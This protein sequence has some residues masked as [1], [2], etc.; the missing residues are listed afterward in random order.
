MTHVVS[1]RCIDCRYTDCCEVCPVACFYEIDDPKM[2]VIDPDTCIDCKLCVPQCPVNAI[3]G[4]DEL[5]AHYAEMLG[6]NRELVA[7]G[8]NIVDKK[9]AVA[10]ALDLA[11]VQARERAAGFEPK[12]PSEAVGG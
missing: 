4:D 11:G 3:Y 12:E 1:A 7:L 8:T 2:L 6:L 10:G 9:E 5:P